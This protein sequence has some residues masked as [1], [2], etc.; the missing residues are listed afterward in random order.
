MACANSLSRQS[1]EINA[2]AK[3]SNVLRTLI[4]FDDSYRRKKNRTFSGASM[5]L[6]NAITNRLPSH[7]T[8]LKPRPLIPQTIKEGFHDYVN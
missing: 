6:L 5:I 1:F 3:G 8:A 2:V 4:V 7:M